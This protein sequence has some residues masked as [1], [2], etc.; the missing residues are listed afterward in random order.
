MIPPLADRMRPQCLQDIVGQEHVTVHN[1]LFRAALQQKKAFSFIVFGPPGVGKTTFARCVGKAFGLSLSYVSAAQ[2]GI[3]PL[4]LLLEQ[5][6]NH[7]FCVLIDEIHRFTRV[8]QDVL[9]PAIE[10]GAVT[11]IGATTENPSF[12]LTPALLSRCQVFALHPLSQ[13]ALRSLLQKALREDPVL[14]EK[15]I[16]VDD[17]DAL[18]R[19]CAGDARRMLNF[20][21]A[22]CMQEGRILINAQSVAA[23]IHYAANTYDKNASHHYDMISAFI[24]SMRGS[25]PNATIYWLARMLVGGEDIVFIARRMVIFAAEDVGLANPNALLLAEACLSGVRHIGMPEARI[26]LSECAIYLSL[27]EKSNSAYKAIDAAMAY[28]RAHPTP[29]SVPV[30]IRNPSSQVAKKLGHGADYLYPHDYDNHFVHQEY[31]P[32]ELTHKRFYNPCPNPTEEKFARTLRAY[33][34]DKYN[35]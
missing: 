28:V 11:L 24:K 29:N 1:V 25:D 14:R 26:V 32:P 2:E 30:A 22:I 3:K 7:P 16:V 17:A 33:W 13:T 27:C 4:K 21:E 23:A 6:K 35:Y 34:K 18:I 8:Q 31:L 12:A 19:L 15:E 20:L 5:H 9:L 10:S